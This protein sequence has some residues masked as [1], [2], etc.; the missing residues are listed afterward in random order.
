MES[1]LRERI[2]GLIRLDE[3]SAT[4]TGAGSSAFTANAG[5]GAQYA[6]PRAFRKDKDAK[7]AEHIYYYKL[8]FKPVPKIKPR[9]YDIKKIY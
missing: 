9:S 8:G 1:K 2:R 6:T 5:T 3:V 4:A 7:G